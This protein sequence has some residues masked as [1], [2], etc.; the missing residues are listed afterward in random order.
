MRALVFQ[1][2]ISAPT[3]KLASQRETMIVKPA[4]AQVRPFVVAV[5]RD[6]THD[7]LLR[8]LPDLQD[9]R[10]TTFAA[11]TLVSVGT[12][13]LDTVKGPFVY[14][15]AHHP[16][17]TSCSIRGEG[18]E[19]REYLTARAPTRRAT[20]QVHRHHLR[21]QSRLCRRAAL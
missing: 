9:K 12:H 7:R 17:S 21:L 4:C 20:W 10:T 5:M 13:D 19:G 15:R 1:G 2:K 18:L 14:T 3:H 16:T 8:F 11:R 6:I